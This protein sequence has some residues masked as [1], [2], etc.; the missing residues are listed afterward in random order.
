M[1]TRFGA[2]DWCGKSEN[3]AACFSLLNSPPRAS[4]FLARCTDGKR[5][6]GFGEAARCG[7]PLHWW[8][9]DEA[10]GAIDTGANAIK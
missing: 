10:K 3:N 9:L 8:A 5:K 1:H 6:V 2:R 4:F 7:F